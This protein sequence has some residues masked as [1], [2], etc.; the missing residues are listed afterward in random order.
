MASS[1]RKSSM[2]V[3]EYS[4][5][6]FDSVLREGGIDVISIRAN[7]YPICVKYA[8]RI[9]VVYRAAAELDILDLDMMAYRLCKCFTVC[10]LFKT[11][12]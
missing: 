5:I 2:L 9:Q 10:P 3:T 7:L 6:I 11:R 1:R 12:S 4:S 8:V